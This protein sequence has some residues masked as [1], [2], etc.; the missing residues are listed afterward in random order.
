MS[1]TWS[2]TTGCQNYFQCSL[3]NLIVRLSQKIT[4]GGNYSYINNNE[5]FRGEFFLIDYLS[6]IGNF[7]GRCLETCF[8]QEGMTDLYNFNNTVLATNPAMITA[9]NRGSSSDKGKRRYEFAY[10]PNIDLLAEPYPLN[11]G[12]ELKISFDR[13]PY[14]CSLI[15]MDTITTAESGS[16]EIKD[17]HALIDFVSSPFYRNYFATIENTPITYT[18]EAT[19]VLVR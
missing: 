19:D 11:K 18:Y 1:T 3:L 9:R 16:I 14:Q 15:E 10:V 12:V 4:Q 7:N 13:A 2:T 8:S 17:C 5:Y 6:K